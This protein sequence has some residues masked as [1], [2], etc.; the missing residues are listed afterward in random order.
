[1]IKKIRLEKAAV[2]RIYTE[3]IYY[4]IMEFTL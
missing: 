1:M 2:S 4:F 3:G